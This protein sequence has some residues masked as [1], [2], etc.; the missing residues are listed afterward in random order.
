[1]DIKY[2]LVDVAGG[3]TL[4]VRYLSEILITSSDKSE[5]SGFGNSIL[6]STDPVVSAASL[7]TAQGA[8]SG[9]SG[10][11]GGTSTDV[12]TGMD[13]SIDIESIKLAVNRPQNRTTYDF[14]RVT[15]GINDAV[16]RS[17]PAVAGDNGIVIALKP[18]ARLTIWDGANNASV[19][20]AT[21]APV[22]TD[23]SLVVALN[24]NSIAQNIGNA[25][26]TTTRTV[27]AADS[28]DLL[29]IGGATD[30]SIAANSASASPVK[31]ILRGLWGYLESTVGST[32]DVTVPGT[33][34]ASSTVKGLMRY[35]NQFLEQIG[36]SSDVVVPGASNSIATIKQLIRYQA[37]FLEQLGTAS[38]VSIPGSSASVATIKQLLRYQSRFIEQLGSDGDIT[39]AN[40]SPTAN[41]SIKSLLRLLISYFSNQGNIVS[42]FNIADAG[43]PAGAR[44]KSIAF[45]NLNAS[46]VYLQIHSKTAIL[47]TGDVPFGAWI[48]RVPANSSFV[49]GHADF[50]LNG[51]FFATNTRVGIS[52]THAT[53]TAIATSNSLS[54]EVI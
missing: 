29:A 43:I 9:I 53:Y 41:S 51:R 26:D 21:T 11:G 52:S 39:V 20:A 15:D 7:G 36:T 50:G 18:D 8:A 4:T 42:G 35:G 33:A 25:N 32:V 46:I 12:A 27:L 54:I 30:V 22:A 45:T 3:K 47:A 14:V 24:P 49:L 40:P 23:K 17:T 38:D 1:L 37:L 2:D 6:G 34:I 48:I 19:A 10:S 31:G 13:V 5:L 28:P 16:I 44:V